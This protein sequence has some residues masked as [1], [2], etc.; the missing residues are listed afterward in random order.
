M[1]SNFVEKFIHWIDTSPAG[2]SQWKRQLHFLCSLIAVTLQQF[3][4]NN[5]S[6]RSGAMTCTLLLSLVP[7]LA[8]STAV[9][10]GLG[11]GDQL[12]KIAFSYIDNIEHYQGFD[13]HTFGV[14]GKKEPLPGISDAAREESPSEKT[15]TSAMRSAVNTIFNYVDRTNFATLGSFGVAGILVTVL[16]MLSHVEKALNIIWKVKD[17]RPLLRKLSDYI[18]LLFLFPLSVNIAFAASTFL[19]HPVLAQKLNIFL[20]FAWLQPLLF[21][22]LPIFFIAISL[23]AVYI[24]FPC[25]KVKSIPAMLGALLAATLWFIV[26]NIYISLQVG[27]AKYNA[28]YGTFA[29]APLFLAWI[30]LGWLFILLGAQVAWTLQNMH[31]VVFLED[32]S[33]PAVSLAA[34]FD[35]LEEIYQHF[36]EKK[37]VSTEKLVESLSC[38]ESLSRR[39][40]EMMIESGLLHPS[41][42]DERLL[43]A[44]PRE[45][46]H[47]GEVVDLI[48][49]STVPNTPGGH[50]SGRI[51]TA[52]RLAAEESSAAD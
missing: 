6:L 19:K 15:L 17:G 46:F 8:M 21:Q 24:F 26:Q 3:L 41:S 40:V 2:L 14:R 5:L 45:K 35:I 11:G 9:V 10:K 31:T 48:L 28:I 33:K 43:P 29:S 39:A 32:D 18:T 52:A 22:A 50:E 23:Y 44:V 49:G 16:L 34:A 7:M 27:V 30:Y 20:P 36:D 51:L 37:P 4:R 12:K 1:L 47:R 38:S 25:T 13:S 42:T